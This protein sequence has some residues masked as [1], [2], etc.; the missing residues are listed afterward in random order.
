MTVSFHF[1]LEHLFHSH[2]RRD[3]ELFQVCEEIFG[4]ERL[5]RRVDTRFNTS[6]CQPDGSQ[7]GGGAGWQR[8]KTTVFC[9]SCFWASFPL[10]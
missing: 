10:V 3:T 7:S 6:I 5:L 2:L 4:M 9:I 8:A 1:N